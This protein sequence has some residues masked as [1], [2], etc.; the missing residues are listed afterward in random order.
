MK[1]SVITALI[2]LV[3]LVVDGCGPKKISDE[4]SSACQ[5]ADLRV[6]V[7]SGTM[8]IYWKSSCDELISGYNI[9]INENPLIDKY[10]GT[11]LPDAVKPFNA[12]PYSGD[13]N[14]DDG[15]EHFIAEG[16]ENGKKYFVSVRIVKPDLTVSRPSNE[17]MAVCGPSG[18]IELPVRHRSEQDG[19]SFERNEYVRADALENDIYFFSD[20]QADYLNSPAKLSA[21]QKENLLVRLKLKGSL[22]E[23]RAKVR[24]TSDEPREQKVV[25]RKGDWLLLRTPEGANAIIKVVEISGEGADRQIRLFFAYNPMPGEMIF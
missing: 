22:E 18:E 15:V 24:A 14:P 23:I 1:T 11:R 3:I 12:A 7:N 8:D 6:D 9:Y 17:V 10:P 16:L 2:P 4:T 21:F 25:V 20:G 5:P 13:T 19:F